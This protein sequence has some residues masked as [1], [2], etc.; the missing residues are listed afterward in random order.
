LTT[1]VFSGKWLVYQLAD[2]L[3]K[4]KAGTQYVVQIPT[5]Y[6]RISSW[7]KLSDGE[8]GNGK[9]SDSL[10]RVAKSGRNEVVTPLPI[11]EQS[12]VQ[13]NPNQDLANGFQ[14]ILIQQ[15]MAQL[16]LVAEETYRVVERIEHGQMDDRIG[17]LLAGKNGISLALSMPECEESKMQIVAEGKTF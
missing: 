14:N 7:E 13:G 4:I 11:K 5:E 12:F 1:E 2:V 15:Q 3:A 16:A 9:R 8:Q 17:L 10:M 6:S